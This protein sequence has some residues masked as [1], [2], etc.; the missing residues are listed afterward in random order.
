MGGRM[1]SCVAVPTITKMSSKD[2]SY[3]CTPCWARQI[4]CPRPRTAWTLVRTS[5]PSRWRSRWGR[6]PR[7]HSAIRPRSQSRNVCEPNLNEK[8]L[9]SKFMHRLKGQSWPLFCLFLSFQQV[10]FWFDKSVDGVLGIWTPLGRME[11]AD[12][13]TELQRYPMASFLIVIAGFDPQ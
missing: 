9:Q 5:R 13:S 11:D 4:W 1:T 12:E 8:M 6:C 3:A 7:A 2:S 10:T